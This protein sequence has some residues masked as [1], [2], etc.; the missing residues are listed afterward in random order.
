M[1]PPDAEV[2]IPC[3][4]EGTFTRAVAT[5]GELLD[6]AGSGG[7]YDYVPQKDILVTITEETL[8]ATAATTPLYY[9]EALTSDTTLNFNI[10]P[11]GVI[12]WQFQSSLTGAR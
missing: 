6:P 5:G 8:T 1:P 9:I 7:Y 3:T 12:A 4:P 2:K 11:A 10:Y